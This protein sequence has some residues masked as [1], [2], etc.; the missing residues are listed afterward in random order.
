MQ[1]LANTATRLPPG[2]ELQTEEADPSG[3]WAAT[4]ARGS[5]I[6]QRAL[7]FTSW[8]SPLAL[9]EVTDGR[10]QI[11]AKVMHHWRHLSFHVFMHV[12]TPQLSSLDCI[13]QSVFFLFDWLNADEIGGAATSPNSSWMTVQERFTRMLIWFLWPIAQQGSLSV[14]SEILS[15]PFGW[16]GQEP[17]LG[18]LSPVW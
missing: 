14:T 16:S 5:H 17:S 18:P 15:F 12:K 7:A 10:P 3:R 11:W 1:P 8:M 4:N 2:V 6:T 9:L 13:L